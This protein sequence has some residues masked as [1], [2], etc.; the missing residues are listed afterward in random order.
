MQGKKNTVDFE[1]LKEYFPLETVLSGMMSIFE[2]L[3]GLKIIQLKDGE[4][5]STLLFLFLFWPV[6]FLLQIWHDDVLMYKVNDKKSDLLLGY[7]FMDLYQREGK[8]DHP[9]AFLLQSVRFYLR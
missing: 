7:F 5:S 3:F 6:S 4:V 1:I 8:V 2:R 9:F